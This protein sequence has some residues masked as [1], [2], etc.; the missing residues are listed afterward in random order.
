MHE[1]G[2]NYLF[3]NAIKW[4]YPK[5]I[6]GF[7]QVLT[8]VDKNGWIGLFQKVITFEKLYLFCVPM[9]NLTDWKASASSFIL[10]Y[11]KI[12]VWYK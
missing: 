4:L 5:Y 1:I 9:D 3:W 10:K 11:S 8:Q 12:T 6:S 2:P 7:V